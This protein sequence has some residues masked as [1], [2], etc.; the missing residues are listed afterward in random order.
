MASHEDIRAEWQAVK[1][2]TSLAKAGAL[3]AGR[4]T[5][6]GLSVAAREALVERRLAQNETSIMRLAWA[7]KWVTWPADAQLG[8]MSMAWA[9]GAGRFAAFPNFRAAMTA[10]DFAGA[11]QHCNMS[12]K[13]GDISRRNHANVMLFRNAAQ[14]VAKALDPSV[15]HYPTD[16]SIGAPA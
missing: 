15:L 10:G 5:K 16:L 8:I 12:D 13:G 9:M 3:S 4:V 1:A 6:L 11:A 7:A 14:V 2:N